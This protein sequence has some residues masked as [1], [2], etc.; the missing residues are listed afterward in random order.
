M[1]CETHCANLRH[2]IIHHKYISTISCVAKLTTHIYKL[3]NQ[4]F[5][6]PKYRFGNSAIT[7][8]HLSF[9][10]FRKRKYALSNIPKYGR[11]TSIFKSVVVTTVSLSKAQK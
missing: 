5:G 3:D 4:Y 10:E 1:D 9:S 11:I 8:L 6:F 2:E 7:E